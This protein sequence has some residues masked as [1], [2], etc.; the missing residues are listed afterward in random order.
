[1][2]VFRWLWKKGIIG[3]FLTGFFL[4]LPLFV[5]VALLIWIGNFVYSWIGPESTLGGLIRR[6]GLRFVAEPVA[7]LVGW[8]IVVAAIW[9]VG[10]VATTFGKERLREWASLLAERVP[11]V[12]T[13]YN[14]AAQTVQLLRR[15]RPGEFQN[16][17]VVF[18]RFSEANG[19]GFLGLQV[20]N[21]TFR[22]D[23][24]EYYLIYVPTSPLPMSGA[25]L[26]V[27]VENVSSVNMSVDAVMQLYLSIGVLGEAVIPA[28]YQV[29]WGT[30]ASS[31]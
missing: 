18:C 9:F 1:M 20:V 15:D 25:L 16:A 17:A 8:S 19:A 5:T 10:A 24:R 30:Q 3:N 14:S 26:L 13:I 27:P 2:A 23:G 7:I 4:L 6:L 29:E 11:V 21:R 28:A 12:G 22:F 31:A